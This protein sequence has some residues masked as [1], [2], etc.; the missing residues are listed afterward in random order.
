MASSY[1]KE[2]GKKWELGTILWIILILLATIFM[3]WAFFKESKDEEEF[4][5]HKNVEH[6][7]TIQYQKQNSH[8]SIHGGF[9]YLGD[10]EC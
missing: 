2:R 8:C 1:K 4:Q 5:K 3:L 7:H 9:D 10:L 6:D